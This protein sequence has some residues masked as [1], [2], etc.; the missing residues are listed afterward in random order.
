MQ[1]LHPFYRGRTGEVGACWM[2]RFDRELA[3]QDNIGL[4]AAVLEDIA[5]G[6]GFDRLVYSG[7]SQ[8]VAL[9]FR[10]ALRAPWRADGVIALGGDVPP[11]LRALDAERWRDLRILLGRGRHDELYAEATM[12]ADVAFL[13][14]RPVELRSLVF[15]GGHEWSDRF[16]DA[17]DELLAAVTARRRGAG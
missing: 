11:E 12:S 7:F 14:S 6:H 9:A 13:R 4:V 2:T 1:A 10:A 5:R 17:A 15:E 8:G 3:I 16:N